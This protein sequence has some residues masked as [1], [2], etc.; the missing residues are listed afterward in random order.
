MRLL[1]G[2]AVAW[3]LP[4]DLPAQDRVAQPGAQRFADSVAWQPLL[5]HVIARL[6]QY[7]V[8]A[9]FDSTRHP[10]RMRFP[11]AAPR[12]APFEAHLRTTLRARALEPRDSLFHELEVRPL[13]ISG[14]TAFVQFQVS[15]LRRCDVGGERFLW[16]NYESA[17][18]L[19]PGIHY[20]VEPRG[21]ATGI[22]DGI[23]CPFRTP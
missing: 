22:A 7:I 8:V 3:L 17:Y 9:A 20:W 10:W 2:V 23:G 5:G 16:R 6:S 11:D 15:L 18:V 21:A 19:S 12:W 14:D 1:F 4:S 13:R